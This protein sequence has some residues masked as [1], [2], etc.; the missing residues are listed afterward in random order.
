MALFIFS[1]SVFLS[2]C[3]SDGEERAQYMDA[4]SVGELEIP[5][6]LT[7][8]DTSGAMQLPEPAKKADCN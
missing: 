7:A 8:P 3:S 4:H 2:A 1:T 5:P 6:R